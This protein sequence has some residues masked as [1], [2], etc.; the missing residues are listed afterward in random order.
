MYIST[1]VHNRTVLENVVKWEESVGKCSMKFSYKGQKNL[2]GKKKTWDKTV[3]AIRQ[4]QVGYR[5][6]TH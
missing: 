4:Y 5:F 6:L 2:A 1:I 3:T